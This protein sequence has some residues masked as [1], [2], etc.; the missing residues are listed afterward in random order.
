MNKNMNKKMA[1]TKK[2]EQL[3]RQCFLG[4]TNYCK[5]PEKMS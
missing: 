5:I 2:R 1:E 3:Q 4:K